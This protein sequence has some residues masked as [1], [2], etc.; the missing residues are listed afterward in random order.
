MPE[1]FD[2]SDLVELAQQ[3][4]QAADRPHVERQIRGNLGLEVE[5]RRLAAHQGERNVL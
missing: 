5:E 3:G 2:V 1:L 4:G